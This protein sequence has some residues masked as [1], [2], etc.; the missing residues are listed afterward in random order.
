MFEDPLNT[1]P[2]DDKK[3]LLNQRIREYTQ[4]PPLDLQ[5]DTPR[6]TKYHAEGSI[7]QH[8]DSLN[9]TL[10]LMYS[11]PQLPLQEDTY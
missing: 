11:T 3:S 4:V 8:D 9:L 2:L 6:I 5:N 7:S 10:L 1:Q